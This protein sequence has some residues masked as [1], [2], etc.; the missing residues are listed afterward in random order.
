M[1]IHTALP[2]IVLT[3]ANWSNHFGF[4]GLSAC[5]PPLPPLLPFAPAIG[6]RFHTRLHR[7]T[8]SVTTARLSPPPA[9]R[10][11]RR[12]SDFRCAAVRSPVVWRAGRSQQ[13]SRLCAIYFAFFGLGLR[14]CSPYLRRRDCGPPKPRKKKQKRYDY[15]C[16]VLIVHRFPFSFLCSHK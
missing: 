3:G 11:S 4:F 16:A 6:P 12:R 7:L 15:A 9:Q 14:A 8:R 2:S 10:S 1:I 5:L 13:R